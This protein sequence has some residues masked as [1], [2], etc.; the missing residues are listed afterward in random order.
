M[1]REEIQQELCNHILP[2]WIGLK[3]DEHGGYYGYMGTDLVLD[4][5]AEKGGILHSR[6][7]WTFSHAYM[8]LRQE[9]LLPYATH[10]YEFIRDYF[11]DKEHGGIY[12]SVTAEGK[13][14]DTTKHSY[15][16]AFCIYGLSAYYAATKNQEALDLAQA[17]YELIETRYRDEYGYQEAFTVDFQPQ[18]NEHLSENGV[19]AEKT[20]NTMLHIYEAYTE[21]YRVSGHPGAKKAMY[22]IADLFRDKIYNPEKHRLEVFFDRTMHSLIDL[23]SYGHDIETAWLMERGLEVLGD[24]AYH[25][26]FLPM[27]ADLEKE[28]LTVAYDGESVAAECEKGKV[29]QKRIWWVQCEAMIGFYNAYQKRPQETQYLDAV[30]H[31]W[32]YVKRYMVDN[33]K[34]SEWYNERFYDKA[35]DETKPLLSPW[36]CPYHNTRMCLEMLERMKFCETPVNPNATQKAAQLLKELANVAGKKLITG[37]HT[38][39]V[40]MEECAYIKEV[41]GHLPKLVE[42][43]LLSY[44]PNINT[45]DASPECLKEVYENRNTLEPALALAAEGD[46]I[47]MLCFHWFS[48]IGGRDKAFYAEHTDFDPRRVLVEGTPERK[49]FYSDMDVIAA[50][51]KRFADADIPVL[52]RPFH[53]SEGTWF[54]WG[55]QGGEVAKALYRLMFRYFVDVKGLNNLLWV[56]SA[57]SKES[58]P[59]DDYCDIVGWDI[60]LPAKE[61]TDYARQYEELTRNTSPN[62]VKA[63]TEVGYNPSVKLLEKSHTPWAFYMTWS[64][65]FALDGVY[66]TKEEL[67]QM[68]DSD[69]T[70]KR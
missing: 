51:L 10:A 15:N 26:S 35:V 5:Q 31:I 25:Q 59:G 46:I 4:K 66:N 17:L 52:W 53:E 55:S 14:A 49:A 24:E 20:M 13:P 36:K 41:T 40:P 29:L 67:R 18:S 45:A 34:G 65:E 61:A 43:E 50:L 38:Q 37:Q 6:I 21:L 47:P 42:F 19:M 68:Y 32:E 33:R 63:L 44:S 23:H 48:P 64:K 28:I 1:I 3:D 2:F 12:W 30:T 11:F 69:Y 60:Y 7:L 16:M 62:K 70:I 57:P 56:W 8:E 27:F 39:T 58:Y 9:N 54:W 22:F